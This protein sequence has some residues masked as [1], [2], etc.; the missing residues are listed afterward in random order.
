MPRAWTTQQKAAGFLYAVA[1]LLIIGGGM[2]WWL[3][4]RQFAR[5]RSTSCTVLVKRVEAKLLVSAGRRETPSVRSRDQATLVLAHEVDGRRF[6][7]AEDF[8]YDW[9]QYAPRGYDEGKSYPCRYDPENPG[10]GT[11]RARFDSN[12]SKTLLALSLVVALVGALMPRIF[13]LIEQNREMRRR[14]RSPRIFE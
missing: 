1:V 9:A 12:D 2:H 7:F 13:Q 6:T 4:E 10:V 3:G 8:V 11:V 14:L 5:M